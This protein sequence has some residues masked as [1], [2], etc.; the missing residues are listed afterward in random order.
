LDDKLLVSPLLRHAEEILETAMIGSEEVAIIVGRQ[1]TVRM[2]D[3]A[4][5]SLRAMKTEFG[6]AAVYK[7]ERRG[8]T[9][10][11]EGWDGDK[12]CRLERSP[13]RTAPQPARLSPLALLT[14]APA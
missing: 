13:T 11:V 2:I 4:G 14:A 7:V 6:A 3:P 10:R 9:V 1:G 12:S 8:C 5:W